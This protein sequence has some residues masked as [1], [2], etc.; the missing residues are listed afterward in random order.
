[1]LTIALPTDVPMAVVN[2]KREDFKQSQLV[3]YLL[4]VIHLMLLYT[5]MLTFNL[6]FISAMQKSSAPLILVDLN[7]SLELYFWDRF[8]SYHTQEVH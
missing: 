2:E 1:M 8:F 3:I 7:S 6:P 5:Y 4:T